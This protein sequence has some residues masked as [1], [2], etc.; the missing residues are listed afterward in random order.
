MGQADGLEHP[1]EIPAEAEARGTSVRVMVLVPVFAPR[2]QLEGAKPPDIHAG[3]AFLDMVEMREAVHQT[4]H[5]QGVD[6]ADRAH[7]EK[8]HPSEAENQTNADREDNDRRFGPAPDFVDA[9]GE[10]GSPA[11]FVGGLGL[12]EPAKMRPPATAL[13]G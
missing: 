2:G 6:E 7:P 3:I 13:L 1:D 10:L 9:A 8:A 11:L 12:I 5:V 4:L